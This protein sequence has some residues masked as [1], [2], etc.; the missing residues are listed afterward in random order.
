[1]WI[2]RVRQPA[3]SGVA[4]SRRLARSGVRP[5]AVLGRRNYATTEQNPSEKPSSSSLH[6]IK[7]SLGLA[8][9]ATA[10]FL[11][12]TYATKGDASKISKSF[13]DLSKTAEELSSDFVQQKR[14]L[15]S[16]GVYVWGTN[17]YHVVDPE[18]KDSVVKTPRK[19]SYFDGQVLRDLK[20]GETSGAAITEHGDLVQW[21]KGYSE[22]DYKPAK[23]LTGKNLISL[24]MSHD[25][26]LALS[27]D[28][29]VYSLP[30]AMH[31]QLSGRKP[32][33]GSWVPFWTGKAGVSYRVLQPSL[34]LGEKVTA[35]SGGLEHIL[36]L[37]SS[38]RV[39][40]AASSTEN[41]PSFGQLGIPG[42]TW[43]TRPKGPVDA[44][45]E[46]KLPKDSKVT[47]IATGE[48]HSLLLTKDGHVFTF[49]DNSFGQLGMEFDPSVPFCDTP[50]PVH[51]RNLY[52][53]GVWHLQATGIAA[54]GANSFF[55]VD[56]QHAIGHDEDPRKISNII[57]DT[58]TCGRG[59]WGALG[60]GKWTHLQDSL[61]KVKALS[62]LV[63]YDENTKHII[64]IRPSDISVGTTHVS[65]VLDNKTHLDA[66][67]T[68]TLD[69]ANDS[70][71]DVL[72]WGG[73]E[74][75]QL[76]TGKRSNI[77]K[78]TH[79]NIH[80]GAGLGDKNDLARLQI[81]PFHKG[82][83]GARNVN[84]RQ[85]VECGRHISAVYSSV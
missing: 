3:T 48:Y 16:P 82:K 38:G 1:M 73:N 23:T 43:A 52:R 64:P 11:I 85:R 5:I 56:V 78:P 26:I 70:G 51:F 53:G 54:G 72:W 62:G 63:E 19:M 49:G 40:S 68:S 33:E 77:S 34:K 29:K 8:G 21:G 65:A 50:A 67:S 42:L 36:L 13:P 81:L 76:G 28:G 79:I 20:L 10:A 14:S 24:C 58:W 41:F 55:V 69:T 75:F 7:T 57:S 2:S 46:I 32:E 66:P 83:V 71:L 47:Q 45:H 12:Y 74:H 15:K 44:C 4:I 6:W 25:R 9:T 39:F 22:S 17:V 61:T 80:P 37:T 18:S 30:I 35:I 27:G 59:I 84:M 60:T 31:D